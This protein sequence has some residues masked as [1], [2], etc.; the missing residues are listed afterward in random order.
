M[1]VLLLREIER[2]KAFVIQH[3]AIINKIKINRMHALKQGMD[4]GSWNHSL[5]RLENP[6]LAG[7]N[8]EALLQ[9]CRS[10]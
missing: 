5:R 3:K 2:V 4:I 9:N 6:R 8:E 1:G 7:R 10:T